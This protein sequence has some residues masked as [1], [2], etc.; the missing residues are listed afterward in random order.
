METENLASRL[1]GLEREL[2]EVKQ[3]TGFVDH[4]ALALEELARLRALS[5]TGATEATRTLKHFVPLLAK[6]RKRGETA[7]ANLPNR[8]NFIDVIRSLENCRRLFK[9]YPFESRRPGKV[10]PHPLPVRMRWS[11]CLRSWCGSTTPV[12]RCPAFCG[13]EMMFVG[14]FRNLKRSPRLMRNEEYGQ[15]QKPIIR[16]NRKGQ[17]SG[18]QETWQHPCKR[19]PLAGGVGLGEGGGRG[20]TAA[21]P[22]QKRGSGII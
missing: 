14:S 20:D 3:Q 22:Y 6:W 16:R 21:G 2:S 17:K 11:S 4:H 12:P 8:N 13:C 9:S 18:T 7:M 1:E 5:D 19:L 15:R 10:L